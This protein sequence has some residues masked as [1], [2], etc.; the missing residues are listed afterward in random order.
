LSYNSQTSPNALTTKKGNSL[1]A[2]KRPKRRRAPQRRFDVTRLEFTEL[3]DRI[4]LNEEKIRRNAAKLDIQFKR[5]AQMQAEL[6]EIRKQLTKP[7]N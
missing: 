1:M 3:V 7:S 2:V 5:F 4:T 6:D